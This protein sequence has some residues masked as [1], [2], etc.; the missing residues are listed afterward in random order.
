MYESSDFFVKTQ[1]FHRTTQ[2]LRKILP[3][4]GLRDFDFV[5]SND[6]V[7]ELE[8]IL[9]SELVHRKAVIFS[10][11]ITATFNKLNI[12]GE[13]SARVSPCFS[14][15]HHYINSISF[16]NVKEILSS[17]VLEIQ[18]RFDDFIDKGIKGL[19]SLA[20]YNIFRVFKR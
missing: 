14:S 12:D 7:E 2:I 4:H 1:A 8:K 3:E 17:F 9:D 5:T 16:F 10:L 20:G 15:K 18:H 6:G 11:S 13:E 19:Y